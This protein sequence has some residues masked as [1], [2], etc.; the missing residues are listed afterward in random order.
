MNKAICPKCK[1]E[2]TFVHAGNINVCPACGF[3]Y[4]VGPPPL[5][6]PEPGGL[7]N[8]FV[9]LALIMAILAVVGVGVVFIG[10]IYIMR[11]F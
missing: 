5:P 1:N 10:C 9:R 7:L 11:G 3:Q 4:E 2:V 6:Y 8:L